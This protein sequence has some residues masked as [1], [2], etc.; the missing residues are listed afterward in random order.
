[1][2]SDCKE[3]SAIVLDIGSKL[4]RAGFSGDVYPKASFPRVYNKIR[5]T[6]KEITQSIDWDDVEK[7]WHNCYY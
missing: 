7:A 5:Q 4:C 1:M 6:K 2:I 3:N